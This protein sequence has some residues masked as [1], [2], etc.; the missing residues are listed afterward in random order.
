MEFSLASRL[1]ATIPQ[2]DGQQQCCAQVSA[3][4][5]RGPSTDLYRRREKSQLNKLSGRDRL[6]AIG[7]DE[8]ARPDCSVHLGLCRNQLMRVRYDTRA[9]EPNE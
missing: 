7:K 6:P 9:A 3:I 1:T 5:R 2:R 8:L 4:R